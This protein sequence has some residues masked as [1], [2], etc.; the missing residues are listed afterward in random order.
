MDDFAKAVVYKSSSVSLENNHETQAYEH[1]SL[2]MSMAT[3]DNGSIQLTMSPPVLKVVGSPSK[4]SCLTK[5]N[6]LKKMEAQK[7]WNF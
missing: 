7:G 4:T 6:Q 1:V 2:K 5:S 3:A